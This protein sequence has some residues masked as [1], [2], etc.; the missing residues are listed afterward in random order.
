[1]PKSKRGALSWPAWS[2]EQA[3]RAGQMELFV[4]RSVDPRKAEAKRA[5]RRQRR[6]QRQPGISLP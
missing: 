3:R 4:Q 2:L 5:K 6:R 1:M